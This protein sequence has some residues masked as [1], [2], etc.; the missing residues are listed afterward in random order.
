M[1]GHAG[2]HSGIVHAD[3]TLNRSK[4]KVTGLLNFRKLAKP[5]MLAAMTVSCLVGLSGRSMSVVSTWYGGRPRR[6]CV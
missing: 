5:Y 2:R 1:V 3:M 4:V 6:H